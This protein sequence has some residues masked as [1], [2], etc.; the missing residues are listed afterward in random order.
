MFSIVDPATGKPT[1]YFMRLLRDRGIEVDDIDTLVTELNQTV[2]QINGTN[3]NAGVGLTGGGIIGTNS[4]IS[5]ALQTLS[6]SPAGSYTNANIT[7]DSYGRVTAASN[8]TGGGGG[9]GSVPTFVQ[10]KSAALSNIA[11]GITLNAPPANGNVLVAI[12]FNATGTNPPSPGGGWTGIDSNTTLPDHNVMWRITGPNESA[13]QTPTNT[14]DGGAIIIY[15]FSGASQV[16]SGGGASVATN[17]S[18]SQDTSTLIWTLLRGVSGMM[19]GYSGRRTAENGTMGGSFTN[20]EV[21]N[22]SAGV[23]GGNGT[24]IV[25]GHTSKSPGNVSP[26]STAVWPTSAATKTGLLLIW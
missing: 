13:L 19:I 21:V 12:V 11:N 1:D 24:S 2:D 18:V 6:P 4:S 10:S 5:F 7:V 8:G 22:G 25:S 15:E 23:T 16:N 20:G 3:L 9:G 26:S 14:A 17:T